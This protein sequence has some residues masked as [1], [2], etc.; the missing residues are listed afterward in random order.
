MVEFSC[1][2]IRCGMS[3]EL[4]HLFCVHSCWQKH[5]GDRLLEQSRII[6][7]KHLDLFQKWADKE[8][9]VS[10][11]YGK[12]ILH[13]LSQG[14]WKIVQIFTRCS[15]QQ[16]VIVLLNCLLIL[17]L[18]LGQ[19]VIEVSDDLACIKEE[20]SFHGSSKRVDWNLLIL[21]VTVAWFFSEADGV[22]FDQLDRS[23]DF[24]VVNQVVS[25]LA[26]VLLFW[27][28]LQ[29]PW[30]VLLHQCKLFINHCLKLSLRILV[31]ERR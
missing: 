25:L 23:P 20:G 15:Q 5:T 27:N 8:L 10:V 11:Y 13:E 16:L 26:L 30:L 24:T 12:C 6:D 28:G 22:R 9:V 3:N 19:Q 21:V 4:A 1:N 31:W 29:R 18:N 17:S 7:H 14:I 2:Q